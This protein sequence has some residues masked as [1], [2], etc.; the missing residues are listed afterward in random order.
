MSEGNGKQR[1]TLTTRQGHPVSDNQN[2]RTVGP[3]RPVDDG[4]LP[5]PREDEP[6]RPRADPGA[7][8]ARARHHR[9]SATSRPTGKWRRRADLQVHAREAL[10]GAR[11]AAP[12]VA[13][14]FSTVAG[15]RDS[16]EAIRDPRGFAVKFYTEDGNWDLVGN[17]LGVFFIRDA[18]KFPDFIHSQKPI[19]SPSSARSR[20]ACS[21]SS[22]RARSRCTWSRS[23]SARAASRPATAR[24]RASA[25]TP[26][27]GSTRPATPSS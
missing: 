12:S 18:I 21:T 16:S 2:Q 20:T 8:R 6:L 1:K 27:S 22:R 7:G 13:V 26:T 11:Q 17:N 9:R 10:P 3:S 5:L 4:E 19:R 14:R 25:S 24:C 23:C 15:G